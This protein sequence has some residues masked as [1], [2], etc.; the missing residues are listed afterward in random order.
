MR[1]VTKVLLRTTGVAVLYLLASP[2][3]ALLGLRRL[4]RSF[5][6]ARLVRSGFVDCPHCGLRN[7]LDV[8]STCHRCGI[9][10]FGSRLFCSNCR[11]VTRWFDCARCRATIKVL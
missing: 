6:G 4:Q 11:Q 10:E 9:T 8:L 1:D 7:P 3:Y 5:R 2:L